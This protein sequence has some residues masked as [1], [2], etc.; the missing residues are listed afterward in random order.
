MTL[1]RAVSVE[2][3]IWL[4]GIRVK[5]WWGGEGSECRRL[6]RERGG[7]RMVRDRSREVLC[8][9]ECELRADRVG[10]LGKQVG[11]RR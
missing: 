10:T 4:S 2:G 6:F 7:K 11:M 9:R 3:T 1:T 8:G 5:L